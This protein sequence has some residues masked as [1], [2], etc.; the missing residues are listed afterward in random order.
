VRVRHLRAAERAVAAW[1]RALRATDRSPK[2]RAWSQGDR[3][4]RLAAVRAY[5]KAFAYYAEAVR[6]L[7]H[8]DIHRHLKRATLIAQ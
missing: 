3:I 8:A 7:P 1:E 4:V 6:P 5:I 2:W